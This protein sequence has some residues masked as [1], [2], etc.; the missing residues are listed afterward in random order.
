M[1]GTA[2]I[3]WEEAR[4]ELGVERAATGADWCASASYAGQRAGNLLVEAKRDYAVPAQLAHVVPD[5]VE[6]ILKFG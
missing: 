2:P 6:P 4:L 1:V 5:V 3:S